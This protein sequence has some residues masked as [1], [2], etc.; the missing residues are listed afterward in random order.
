MRAWPII[1]ARTR[2]CGGGSV[3]NGVVAA[4]LFTG[5]DYKLDVEGDVI[6]LWQSVKLPDN[7]ADLN[8]CQSES[9]PPP[10]MTDICLHL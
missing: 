5:S 6:A 10:C 4:G 2:G 1:Y 8:K 3:V 7:E 9:H